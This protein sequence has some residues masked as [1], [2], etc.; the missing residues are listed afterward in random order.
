MAA[1][2]AP[3][4]TPDAVNSVAMQVTP[5]NVLQATTADRGLAV[6]PGVAAEITEGEH[7]I[8]TR[9]H[10]LAEALPARH[11]ALVYR[12]AAAGCGRGGV[13]A[14]VGAGHVD[15]VRHEITVVQQ[16]TVV[17]GRSPFLAQ[18][19]TRTHGGWWNGAGHR[20]SARRTRGAVPGRRGRGDGRDHPRASRTSPT[21]SRGRSTGRPGRT[22]GR[23]RLGPRSSRPRIGYTRSATVSPR[24]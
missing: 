18:L 23:R 3:G 2:P 8:P 24:C 11:R 13:R 4:S 10:T 12:G 17:S 7:F 15:F 14:R 9:V 19:K 20:R 22:T 21:R 5:E 6:Q 1:A 16:L